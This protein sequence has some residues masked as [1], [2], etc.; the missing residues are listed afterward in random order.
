[1]P[2][3]CRCGGLRRGQRLER[4][5]ALLVLGHRRRLDQWHR[6]LAR[7]QVRDRVRLVPGVGRDSLHVRDRRRAGA[8]WRHPWLRLMHAGRQMMHAG[9]WMVHSG[10]R[11]VHA[12]WLRHGLLLRQSHGVH[13]LLLLLCL[14]RR[15]VHRRR[16]HVGRHA[17]VRGCIHAR[18]KVRPRAPPNC[19]CAR[20][21]HLRDASG[22][23]C[24][25]MLHMYMLRLARPA[26]AGYSS[27]GRIRCYRPRRTSL[28][29]DIVLRLV[30]VV[31]VFDG[32]RPACLAILVPKVVLRRV[33]LPGRQPRLAEHC[34]ATEAPPGRG[35]DDCHYPC[36][37][38]QPG[39][40][41][42]QDV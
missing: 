37:Q 28:A 7:L 26:A 35:Y 36:Y 15:E 10:R 3:S 25:Q 21:A 39:G 34:G 9:L 18:C 19:S 23:R 13:L 17:H 1:M 40:M 32:A 5:H 42:E 2:G 4:L 12:G 8:L 16:A 30:P 27:M 31:A 24:A 38:W 20:R 29:F 6:V 11:S 14:P 33:H 41:T 22:A